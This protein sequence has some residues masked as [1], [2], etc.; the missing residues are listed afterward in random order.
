MASASPSLGSVPE[1]TSSNKTRESFVAYLHTSACFFICDE[2]E[3]KE[4][5]TDCSS[6]ISTNTR[7]KNG[8]TASLQGIG[9]PQYVISVNKPMIFM[10]T[11][12]PPVFG[13]VINNIFFSFVK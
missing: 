9:I 11:V 8:I 1:P 3:D 6:P 10:D 7:S 12:L 13:P 5:S 2:K 4:D